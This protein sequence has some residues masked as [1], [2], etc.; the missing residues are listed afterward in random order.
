MSHRLTHLIA[1]LALAAA[2]PAAAARAPEAS[3][4]GFVSADFI[5]GCSTCGHYPIGM[6][7][8]PDQADSGPDLAAVSYAGG[9]LRGDIPL[10]YTLGGGAAYAA[11]AAFEGALAMPLLTAFAWADNEPV[12]I[13]DQPDVVIGIDR[14]Q[15]GATASTLREY[16]YVGTAPATYTFSFRLTASLSGSLASVWAGVRL[17]DGLDPYFEAGLIDAGFA[18]GSGAQLL[19]P[20]TPLDEGFSVSVTLDPGQSFVMLASLSASTQVDYAS[21]DVLADAGHTLRLESVSGGDPLLLVTTP[22]PEPGTG[23][24]LA[25]GLLA[26]AGLLRRR[27]PAR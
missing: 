16:T 5:I 21:V 26:M 20:T 12:V 8:S 14:Y 22:V 15:V 4:W 1:T 6:S 9:P 27:R 3:A 24:S 18:G 19:G 23:A 7:G 2:L 17:H 25:L 10:D 11:T 13:V